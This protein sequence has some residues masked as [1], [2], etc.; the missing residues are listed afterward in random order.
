MKDISPELGAVV[1]EMY[2]QILQGA[3]ADQRKQMIIDA[4]KDP[5]FDNERGKNALRLLWETHEKRL[6]D[7]QNLKAK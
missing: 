3:D 7:E 4:G 1:A 6:D 2:R 5:I